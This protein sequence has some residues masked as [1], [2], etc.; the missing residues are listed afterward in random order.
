MATPSR[1]PAVQRIGPTAPFHWLAWGW[2]ALWA[3]W[4]VSLPFGLAVAAVCAGVAGSLLAS[5]LAGWALTLTFGFVFV[6]PVLAMGNYETGRRLEQR[7]GFTL[8]T[9]FLPPGTL[10]QDVAYLGLLLFVIFGI[11]IQ[12]AQI[13]Y[14]LSTFQIHRTVEA[15]VRFALGTAEGHGMLVTGTIVGGAMAFL[16]YVL[17]VIAAPML[18]DPRNGFFEAVATSVRAVNANVLP[19]LV[20]AAILAVLTI[21]SAATG[22]AALIVVFPWLGLASWRAY[23]DL[24]V[25]T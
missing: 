20:W 18:L 22:F 24:V 23:R 13:V 7:L 15:F 25:E 21:G 2:R 10:R 16:T 11:W 1:L 5:N 12:A 6:A 3:S 17:F 4:R 19:M 8:R 9:T 14:G